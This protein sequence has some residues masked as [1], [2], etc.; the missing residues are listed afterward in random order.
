[1]L[2]VAGLMLESA[3]GTDLERFGDYQTRLVKLNPKL[4]EGVAAPSTDNTPAPA[5]P[6]VATS[7]AVPPADHT[8]A[9]TPGA[10]HPFLHFVFMPT[11][12]L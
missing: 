1:M 2:L 6:V 9:T 11:T 10:C 4:G 12:P 8:D 7:G 5:A 3:L